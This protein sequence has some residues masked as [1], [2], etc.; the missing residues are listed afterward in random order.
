MRDFTLQIY[1]RLCFAIKDSGYNPITFKSYCEGDFDAESNFII[2]RHDVDK[3]PYNALKMAKI[4]KQ[5]DILST[6]FFRLTK[7]VFSPKT[8]IEIEHL[9]HEIGY[10]YEVIDKA[11]GDERKAIKIF[12]RE[13]EKLRNYCNISTICMHGNPMTPWLNRDL[14]ETHDFNEYQI[15]G[16]PYITINYDE[17]LYLTDTGRSWKPKSEIKDVAYTNP[18]F[19]GIIKDIDSTEKLIQYI[20]TRSLENACIN[21]HPQRW[22]DEMIPWMKELLLQNIKNI[23]KTGIRNL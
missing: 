22:N 2:I 3:L 21:I 19:E 14:W 23:I 5:H 15:I 12:E 13:L 4:E 18:K 1:D 17:V 9:G 8:M 6:Y 11:R 10:H 16:E 7:E 20:R